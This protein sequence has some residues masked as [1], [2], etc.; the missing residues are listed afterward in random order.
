MAEKI[1]Y[2][3]LIGLIE[4][5]T[6]LNQRESDDFVKEW[7]DVINEGLVKDGQVRI[8]QLGTFKLQRVD[9]RAG[10]NPQNRGAITIPAHTKVVFKGSKN[11]K[12]KVN[13]KYNLL[14][15]TPI[16]A[17]KTQQQQSEDERNGKLSS[18]SEKSEP[19]A[20][21]SRQDYTPTGVMAVPVQK[22]PEPDKVTAKPV[23]E[24][25]EVVL[26]RESEKTE[27]E[28][29]TPVSAVEKEEKKSNK[30]GYLIAAL[31]LILLIVL[32]IFWPG[33]NE[34]AEQIAEKPT[35]LME[36]KT[37]IQ[38]EAKSKDLQKLVKTEKKPGTPGGK[39]TVKAGDKLWNL[40]QSFYRDA[41][42]W[43]NIYRVNDEKI[44]NPDI[45]DLGN[46]IIVPPLEGT[47]NSLTNTD[48]VNIASGFYMTYQAYKRSG[49]KW[50]KYYLWVCKKYSEKVFNEKKVQSDQVD[51][52][53]V[54]NLK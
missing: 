38:N 22:K 39:H 32:Y 23:V 7:I 44:P 43:P 3:D 53:F 13:H 11:L 30:V 9:E 16:P 52:R 17:G 24:E 50:A 51:V 31:I 2:H 10:I 27:V 54:M 45:L 1:T 49:N 20:E 33:G 28:H 46:S 36:E 47:I 18:L 6:G 5:E 37:E 42:L 40:S 21:K 41:Y 34:P 4:K 19:T 15:A 14:K 25:E 35:A 12:E 29:K 48:S 8:S 26:K